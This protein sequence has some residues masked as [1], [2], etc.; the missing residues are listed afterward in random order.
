MANLSRSDITK[1]AISAGFNSK[2]ADIASAIAIAESGGNPN[3]HKG[4]DAK[5]DSYGLWQIN[6]LGALRADRTKRYGP[7]EGLYDPAKNAKAAFDIYRRAGYTFR[8]WSTFKNGDYKKH[9][10]DDTGAEAVANAPGAI[11]DAATAVPN[12]I[13]AFSNNLFKVGSNI[14]GI[15]LAVVLLIVGVLILVL[16]NGGVAKKA[17]NL[18]PVGKVAKKL[19]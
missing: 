14:G 5:D 17:L 12:A 1:L 6:Y 4:P 11:A 3:A 9:L 2:D 10:N 13:S 19:T 7:P 15:I 8:D 18:T 16:A